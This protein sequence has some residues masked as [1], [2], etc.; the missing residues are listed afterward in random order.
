MAHLFILEGFRPRRRGLLRLRSGQ[1]FVS[2]KGPK[3]IFACARPLQSCSE[4]DLRGPSASAPNN[5]GSG[6]RY[7][8]TAFAE[9]SIRDGGSAAHKATETEINF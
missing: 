8:Q 9:K 7:A 4:Q 5:H 6:T 1:A 2:A 3:T